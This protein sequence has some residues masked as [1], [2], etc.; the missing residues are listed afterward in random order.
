MNTLETLL[1]AGVL[2]SVMIFLSSWPIQILWNY[3]LVGAINGIN[4]IGFWQTLGI[5][6]LFNIIKKSIKIKI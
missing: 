2:I 5:V 4:P 3:C 6:L 1:K